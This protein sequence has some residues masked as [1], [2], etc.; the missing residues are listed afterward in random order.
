[1]NAVITGGAGFLGSHLVDRLLKE[2]WDKVIV[3]DNLIT[4]SME[5][6]AHL[7]GDPRLHFQRTNV[8]DGISV[9][10]HVDFVF[11]FASPASPD[12]FKRFPIQVMKVGS[13]GTMNALGF[14]KAKKA[15]FMV[16]STSEVYGDPL[17]SPQPE[18]YWGNVN[19]IGPRSV[20]DEAKR[21][22]E[23]LTMA[24]RTQHGLDTRIVRF[25]NT[26][27]PRMRLDDGRVVPNF[28][29]QALLGEPLTVYGDGSQTRSFGYYEDTIDGVYRLASSDYHEPVNIGTEEERTVLE[30]AKAVI[31][32]SGSSSQIIHLP[33]LTDDPKQRR[34]DL[35]RARTIL[36][37]E[38][39][40]SLEEGLKKT[41]EYFRGKL[42]LPLADTG[43]SRN[44]EGEQ[45]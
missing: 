38:Y 23:A 34:P 4:G 1:M 20:Y 21:F 3:L 39:K 31:A 45:L 25:F 15:K 11:H 29:K 12:D 6:L 27:G 19:P 17:I 32:I 9:D 5:N 35:T 26:Y 14:A 2:G 30:F 42:Q 37:Y 22:S 8:S 13:V 40:V 33:A 24:Y 16:A 44:Q 10:G 41:I 7:E 36:G 28:V 18:T 43:S